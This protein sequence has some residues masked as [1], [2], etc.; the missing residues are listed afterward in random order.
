MNTA[1]FPMELPTSPPLYIRH[2]R[3]LLR[4][5]DPEE[6]SSENRSDVGEQEDRN[7]W[8]LSLEGIIEAG[9]LI[10][11]I[12]IDRLLTQLEYWV[13]SASLSQ[14]RINEGLYPPTVECKELA[15]N[16]VS[17]LYAEHSL[18]PIRVSA[19]VE[20]GVFIKYINHINKKEL[21]IEI[22]NDLDIAALVTKGKEI[23]ASKD[24]VDES[25]SEI[26]R[27]FQEE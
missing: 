10:G 3:P 19:T 9:K 4:K 21:S 24:I 23:I 12:K 8:H 26:Y 2:I 15:K 17:G 11:K 16:I 27:I 20:E 1:T 6:D 13:S 18:Y 14:K 7:G 22:Y 5:E 25:F